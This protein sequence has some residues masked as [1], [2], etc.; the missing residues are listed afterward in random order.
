MGRKFELRTYH[1][2]IKYLFDQPTLNTRQARW[3][4]FLCEFDFEIKHIK[5]KENKVVDVLGKKVQEMH[6]ASIS[7]CQ[8]YLKQ[9][10]I[11][12]NAKDEM[13]VEVKDKLLHQS[14][15]KKYEGY[16]LE[17][18]GLITYKSR[19]YIP[20]VAHLRR[21]FMDEIH[22]TPYSG[23]PGYQ[24]MIATARKKYFFPGMK[25]DMDVYISRCMKCQQVKVE[26]QH[27]AGLLQPFPVP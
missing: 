9:E 4:K 21:V 23:H 15:E 19:I 8:S 20:N 5:G 2:G 22:K 27:R 11:N 10:I 16:K 18:D 26:H 12:R 17:E 13:Y 24:K 14:L 25:K 1:C 6:V 3:L 7:I